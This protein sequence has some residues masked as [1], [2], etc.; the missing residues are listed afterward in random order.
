MTG[1]FKNEKLSIKRR[2]KIEE[3]EKEP[4]TRFKKK[5]TCQA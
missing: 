5:S 2:Q 1:D 4:Q 3:N